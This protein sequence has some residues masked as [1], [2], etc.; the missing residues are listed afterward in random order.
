[1]TASSAANCGQ[2]R[3]MHRVS[4]KALMLIVLTVWLGNADA[5]SRLLSMDYS[6]LPGDRLE[7]KLSLDGQVRLPRDFHSC[8]HT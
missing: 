8:P 4:V 7:F 2:S 6:L 1:M 3:I 5:G